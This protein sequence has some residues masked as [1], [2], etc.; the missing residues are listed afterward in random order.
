MANSRND[1][2]YQKYATVDTLPEST[3]EGYYTTEINLRE[4]Q[5]DDK[6]NKAFYS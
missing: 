6:V 5:K 1:S 4:I 2:R 3:G